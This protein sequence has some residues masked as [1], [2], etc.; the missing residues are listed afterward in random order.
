MV[1]PGGE[2]LVRAIGYRGLTL[3]TLNL[4]VGA[5]I[6]VLPAVVALDL[7]RAAI[8]GYLV[9]GAA[10]ALVALCFA[11]AGTR[12]P[13][14][15]GIYA[16]TDVAFGPFPA[17]LIGNLLWFANGVLANASIATIFA[18]SAG[19]LY[20][21]LAQGL[22][23]ALLLVAIY[24]FFAVI[25]VRGVRVGL[26]FVEAAT[27]AKLA[28]IV[29]VIAAGAFLVNPANLRWEALPSLSAMAKS[30]LFLLFAY[31]GFES[32]FTAG[33]EIR[34]PSRTIPR[35]LPSAL[36]LV[37][38][39]YSGLHLVEQ[40]VLGD[41]LAEYQAAPT[42]EVASRVLGP[43]GRVLL[44]AAAMISTFG[45]LGGE[46]LATPRMLYAF[47]RDGWFPAPLAAV[48]P[49]YRTPHV[50]ILAYCA[51]ACGFALTGTFRHLALIASVATL[52]IY[53]TCC[54]AALRLRRLGVRTVDRPLVL[55]GGPAIPVVALVVLL[56][57]LTSVSRT[58]FAALGVFFAAVTALYAVGRIRRRALPPSR[59]D[60]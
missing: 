32:V 7:G 53:I 47:A 27:V 54:L 39:L 22:P 4:I 37:A 60:A 16:Y 28:P 25:N 2:P 13:A 46:I 8:A 44:L 40:G 45:Y 35:A 6:F 57:M 3:S 18:A 55:P 17:F 26:G 9:C 29:L 11:E 41:R 56:W 33:G 42:A 43:S 15:G 51:L 14:T 10:V 21:P 36:L 50:A 30:S 12:V 24:G 38:L 49:R 58:E 34:D 5:S 1:K 48:H 31:S 19:A 23:R 59:A 52:I 20:A